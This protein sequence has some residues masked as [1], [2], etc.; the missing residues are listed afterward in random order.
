MFQPTNTLIQNA[1]CNGKI[2]N[3]GKSETVCSNLNSV[4]LKRLQRKTRFVR[5]LTHTQINN[6]SHLHWDKFESAILVHFIG[7]AE[8]AQKPL[9]LN[10]TK[11]ACLP[12]LGLNLG[13]CN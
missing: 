2:T 11:T 1:T 5:G 9:E 13:Q 7:W 3:T 10:R 8:E 4:G 6:D 12:A